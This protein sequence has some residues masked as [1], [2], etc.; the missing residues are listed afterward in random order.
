MRSDT[1]DHG[2]VTFQG[3]LAYKLGEILCAIVFIT[4]EF[5]NFYG[6]GLYP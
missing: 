4:Q 6:L 5:R 2:A 3:D 1:S